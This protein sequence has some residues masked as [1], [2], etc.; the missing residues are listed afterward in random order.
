MNKLYP[1][2]NSARTRTGS[3]TENEAQKLRAQ[4]L[5]RDKNTCTFCGYKAANWQTINYLDEDSGNHMVTNLT[6]ACPMCNLIRNTTIGCQI[7]GIVELYTFSDHSQK[8]IVQITRKMRS[9]GKKDTEILKFLGL[10]DKVPFKMNRDYL[11]KLFA[12]V[13]SWKGSYGE[14]EEA[15]QYGYSH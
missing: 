3:L 8:E 15:L 2:Y 7:E 13:T 14:V 10:R 1:T 9:Q 12:F 5:K 6:V 4:V 11:K